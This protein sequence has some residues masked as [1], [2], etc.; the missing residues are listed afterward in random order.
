MKVAVGEGGLFSPWG[1]K[2]SA[3]RHC[4]GLAGLA[5]QPGSLPFLP[6]LGA[7]LGPTG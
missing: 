7:G 3:G 4:Q 2:T 5:G 6:R 1:K